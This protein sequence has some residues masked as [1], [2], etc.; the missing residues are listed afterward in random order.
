MKEKCHSN[1]PWYTLGQIVSIGSGF[2]I[3]G[4]IVRWNEVVETVEGPEGQQV[5][6][7]YDAM[8]FDL[9]LPTDVQPGKVA[10]ELYLNSAKDSI[11]AKAQNL[12][13]QREG[14]NGSE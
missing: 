1:L 3:R 14:F 10:V 12:L 4:L 6:Y 11:T 9:A 5:Q 7:A 13:A 2:V 8:K